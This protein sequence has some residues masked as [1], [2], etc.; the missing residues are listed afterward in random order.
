MAEVGSGE[1]LLRHPSALQPEGGLSEPELEAERS[2]RDELKLP[3]RRQ[4][5][6]GFPHGIFPRRP[7]ALISPFLK[8]NLGPLRQ[9]D[10]PSGLE[11]GARLVEGRRRA[12]RAVTDCPRG[13]ESVVGRLV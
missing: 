10:A 9:E 8:I 13:R 2:G 7:V 6:A 12:A 5:F 4:P 1:G 11:V 3:L